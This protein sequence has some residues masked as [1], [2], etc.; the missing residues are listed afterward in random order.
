MLTGSSITNSLVHKIPT[1]YGESII[2]NRK[3]HKRKPLFIKLPLRDNTKVPKLGKYLLQKI[4]PRGNSM[5]IS[6][7]K[8][9][10]L[11]TIHD[12]FYWI[13]EEYSFQ[14]LNNSAIVYR[15]MTIVHRNTTIV[16]RNMT[17]VNRNMTVFWIQMTDSINE[18]EFDG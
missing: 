3:Q 1:F 15:N 16:Y 5:P 13:S 17:I 7:V 11:W 6:A 12:A 8:G 10:P 2:E 14:K 9:K 4:L 18:V